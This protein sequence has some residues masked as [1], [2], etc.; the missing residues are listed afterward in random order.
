M[1][2]PNSVTNIENNTF[3]GCSALTSI[4]IP[5]NVTRIG[6]AVFFACSSLAS[7]TIPD[8]ITRIG[9]WVFNGCESLTHITFE[10]TM[11]E[12]DKVSKDSQWN[13]NTSATYV[14]CSD[15]QVAL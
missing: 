7:V 13:S 1:A 12:W 15:G 14:Q 8:S 3:T 4:T 6:D 11:E 9:K 2:I 5:N 10:G